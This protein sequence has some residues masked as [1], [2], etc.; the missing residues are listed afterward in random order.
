M[1]DKISKSKRYCFTIHNYTPQELTQFHE[2]AESLEKHRYICY[3]LETAPDTGTKHIQGYIELHTTQRLGFVQ[4]YFNIK[5]D[6]KVHKF[7]LEIANGTA[8][9]NKKYTSKDGEHFEFGEPQTQGTRNDLIAI[10][11]RM[12]D[13]PRDL[14]GVVREHGNNYQQIKYAENL[15]PYYLNHRDPEV[16]P[17]VIWICG[18]TGVGKTSLVYKTFGKDNICSVSSY[19]WLG[20]DYHQQECLL[21]DD[22]RPEDLPFNTLLK[23]TDRYP[24]TLERK[25]GHIPLNSPYI[26]ITSPKFIKYTFTDNKEKVEQLLRRVKEINLN[27]I[28]DDSGIDLKN[29]DEKY[30][31]QYVNDYNRDF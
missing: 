6:G 10:K 20:T 17:T 24:F 1:S 18:D 11:R 9:Q 29:L 22:F 7:H 26:I 3:G 21:M 14:T 31:Y 2:L 30:I 13:D 5:R 19:N 23:I 12:E 27:L 25:G 8:E 28:A 16:P 15:Q 4:R